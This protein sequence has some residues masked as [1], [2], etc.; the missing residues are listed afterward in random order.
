MAET[1]YLNFK[2]P[3]NNV[4]MLSE[5]TLITQILFLSYAADGKVP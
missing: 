4:K 3:S 1:Q 5:K 2:S